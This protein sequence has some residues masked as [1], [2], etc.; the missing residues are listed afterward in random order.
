MNRIRVFSSGFLFVFAIYCL[1][2]NP[3]LPFNL[4]SWVYLLTT[5]YFTIFPIKDMIAAFNTTLYKGRQFSKKYF[6]N[7]QLDQINFKNIVQ[8]YNKRAFW[9]LVFQ[10]IFLLIPGFLYLTGYLERIWIFVFFALSNFS[11]FFAIFG[12]CPFNSIF[13]K[14]ECCMEC[15]IYNWDSFFQYSFLISI[16]SPYT[17]WLFCLGF[18]CLNGYT[19]I[20]NIQNTFIKS[21]TII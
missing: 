7:N 4:T 14:P 18:L 5:I 9:L 3:N 17:I 15:H 20:I 12:W 2:K 1:L 11:V 16:P 13:I 8:E 21:V 6:P 10:L 19:C